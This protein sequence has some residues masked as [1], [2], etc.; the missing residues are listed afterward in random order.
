MASCKGPIG[1][2]P[3]G[4]MTSDLVISPPSPVLLLNSLHFY[5][6]CVSS[7]SELITA[8][9]IHCDGI[10]Y[11]YNLTVDYDVYH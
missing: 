6:L 10:S 5:C 7:L 1:L 4:I 8:L 2:L 9:G 3:V 11:K